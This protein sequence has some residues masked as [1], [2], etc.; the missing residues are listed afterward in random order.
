MDIREQIVTP[1]IQ[2]PLKLPAV[3]PDRTLSDAPPSR[4]A[5]TISRTCLECM[6]VKTVVISGMIAPAS[7]PQEMIVASFH[8]NVSSA[9]RC[10]ISTYDAMKVQAIETRDVSH[11]S[12]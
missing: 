8:Q 9:P 11:T 7:V 10:G 6:D 3:R 4:E 12:C 2:N 1:P 5:V